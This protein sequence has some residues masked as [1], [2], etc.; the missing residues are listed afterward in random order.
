MSV[1]V[2]DANDRER[3]ESR[4]SVDQTTGC[5]LWHDQLN[6]T[7]Y[8]MFFIKG[9]RRRA[10]RLSYMMH[11]GPVPGGLGLDHLCRVRNCINPAHLE[12]VTQRENINRGF[13]SKRGAAASAERRRK[14]THCKWGHPLSGS[15]LYVDVYGKRKCNACAALRQRVAYQAK[16]KMGRAPIVGEVE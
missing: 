2:M 8:G 11:V 16:R 5:W 1:L 12:P 3:F 13:W 6:E 15:N 9:K 4:Y 10:H 14:K 7:G